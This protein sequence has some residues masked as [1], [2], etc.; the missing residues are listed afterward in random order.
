[1]VV[2]RR[3]EYEQRLEVQSNSRV[4]AATE[5]VQVD[6]EPTDEAVYVTCLRYGYASTTS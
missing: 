6:E 2:A 1:M 5:P 4:V 3:T